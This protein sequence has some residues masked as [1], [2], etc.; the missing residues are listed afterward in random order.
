MNKEKIIRLERILERNLS[1]QEVERLQRIQDVMGIS[2][3]DGLWDVITA[4][5]YQRNFYDVLP[6]KIAQATADIFKELSVAAEKEV[7]LA[8]GRL[9]EG[10]VE[11]AKKLSLKVHAQTWLLWGALALGLLLLYGSLLLWAG[12]SI[13]SGQ[14]QPPALL[15][16][17]MPVGLVIGVLGF[18][19]GIAL[20]V[21]A[22]RDFAEAEKG[23]W[24]KGITAFG[25]TTVGVLLCINLIC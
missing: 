5:E 23:W 12:Y 24:K 11:Q 15:L 13:G 17:K 16:L 25:F 1:A 3:N 19:C 8:H 20:G 18:V 21:L 22:A 7:A 10:V 4:L 2:D 6:E 9:A 14:A